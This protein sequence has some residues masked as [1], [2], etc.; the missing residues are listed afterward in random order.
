M[1]RFKPG[2][3]TAQL[4]FSDQNAAQCFHL[5]WL[6]AWRPALAP[7]VSEIL[8]WYGI[9]PSDVDRHFVRLQLARI[10]PG[11]GIL[12]HAD[13]GGWVLKAHRLH[14]PLLVNPAVRFLMASGPGFTEVPIGQGDVFEINNAVPHMVVNSEDEERVHLLM[15]VSEEPLQCRVLAPGQ[16]CLYQNGDGVVC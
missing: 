16:S 9:P 13:K 12:R 15:D 7:V 8:S 3:E 11:G 4:I 5:P 2:C 1:A 10:G 14:V 6:D